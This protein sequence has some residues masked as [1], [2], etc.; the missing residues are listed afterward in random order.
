M[1][2]T[3][4]PKTKRPTLPQLDLVRVLLAERA[5]NPTAE[6]I[7][8][9]LN[10][11]RTENLLTRA[12]VSHAIDSLLG[13]P[14]NAKPATTTKPVSSPAFVDA[15]G[16]RRELVPGTPATSPAFVDEGMYR[17]PAT[18]EI[19]RVVALKNGRKIARKVT[20]VHLGDGTWKTK[21]VYSRGTIYALKPEW[22]MTFEECVEYGA[23]FGN[24][25]VCGRDLKVPK[26]VAD[27]IGP[28]CAK[29]I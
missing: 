2:T 1:T 25:C 15:G 29:K 16:R 27:G 17:N 26:S 14:R 4:E 21:L 10:H 18:E 5:G 11:Q 3:T 20:T 28:V 9:Q 22:R 7:R 13:V 24:C 6:K 23:T 8:E 19:F 12:S